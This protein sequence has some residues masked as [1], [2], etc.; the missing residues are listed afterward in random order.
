MILRLITVQ[1]SRTPLYFAC[2]TENIE[3]VK[4]LLVN[5][6]SPWSPDGLNLERLTNNSIIYMLIKIS[7]RMNLVYSMQV[8]GG[9]R[10][11]Y[12]KIQAEELNIVK[13]SQAK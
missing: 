10:D 11:K 5:H 13:D 2:L 1:L 12:W 3:L 7:R 4:F 8:P 6:A 9:K